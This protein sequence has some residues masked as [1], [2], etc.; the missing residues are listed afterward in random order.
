MTTIIINEIIPIITLI[1]IVIFITHNTFP[2]NH[3]YNK[4]K[5]NYYNQKYINLGKLFINIILRTNIVIEK[6]YRKKTNNRK[7]KLV[8]EM[9]MKF[10]EIESRKRN[11]IRKKKNK[12]KYNG[13]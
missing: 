5:S 12:K 7:Q 13:D 4:K 6:S 8:Q 1:L 9:M 10:E 11:F 2:I 3:T